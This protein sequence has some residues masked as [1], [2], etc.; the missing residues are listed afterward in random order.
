MFRRLRHK[1]TVLYAGL[2][3]AALLII[4]GT[5][6][7]V[8]A[9]S[10]E[11]LAREQ[12]TQ[13]AALFDH[14]LRLHTQRL[15]GGANAAATTTL[16]QAMDAR[17]DNAI[18]TALRQL[19]TNATADLAFVV[20]REGLV[21]DENGAA[22]SS[23]PPGLQHALAT[24]TAPEGV[25][26]SG[27]RRIQV[28]TARIPGD[29]GW[30]VVGVQLDNS[31]VLLEQMA[32]L[33]L[34]AETVT[35]GRSGWAFGENTDVLAPAVERQM[36][37]DANR[38]ES[39]N[40]DG[41]QTLVLARPMTSVDGARTA[42]VLRHQLSGA[43]SP[44]GTLFGILFLVSCAGLALLLAG[45]W[46]LAR[47]ITRPISTLEVAA[48][49]L[50]DGVFESVEVNSKDEVAQLAE[51]FNAM[52]AA[53]RERERRITQLAYHDA[54]TRMPNRLA[55]ERRLASAPQPERV[56]LAAIGVDRF[57]DVRGAIGYTLAGALMR[58]L[59]QRLSQLVPNAP[60]AR[61]S[62]DVLGVAILADNDADS[63][64]R[65]DS[66]L[67]A[68]EQ[69]ISLEGHDLDVHVS[70]GVAQPRSKTESPGA[71]IER[72][73]VALDQA[74]AA[75]QKVGLFDEAAY[76]DPARNLS[77]MSE[78]RRAIESDA[79]TLAHQP[80]YDF[81]NGAIKGAEA[82]VRW[83][84]PTRGTIA[85]DLFI[86]MAEETGH[87]RALTEWV[88]KRAVADQRKFSDAGWPLTISVNISGRLLGDDD[89]A[90]AAVEIVRTAPHQLCFEITETA[91][92]DNPEAALQN[93]DLFA[94]K[95]VRI[96][97]D[98]YGSG[99]SSLAYLKQLPA[100]ELKIDKLFVESITNSQRDALLVRST[101]DLAHGL[102]LEVVA[103]GIETPAAFAQ[104]ASMKCDL[105]QG[106]LVARP[107]TVEELIA[108]LGDGR[109]MRF[110]QQAAATGAPPHGQ[111]SA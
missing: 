36:Q 3:C 60:V 6:Y 108:I 99:L 12:M 86:P 32:M 91:V 15:Q 54:E 103:E 95:G 14:T 90:R 105:A 89:F 22:Q 78:M 52:T 80:K 98:D 84:H 53:L 85:P 38:A 17:D 25:M 62:S 26:T 43:L 79:L 111:R 94:S 18:R 100:H 9:A 29:A 19:R 27:D 51:S 33:P 88:L 65:A 109:R 87:I 59:G 1:L 11:R 72:A 37:D 20:T 28:A 44:Y 10:T 71:M 50:K 63:R 42:L 34:R 55:L 66:L 41:E 23:V 39:L 102:G 40:L 107:S 2:F 31:V 35:R 92:I 64:K 57:A 45:T 58:T 46:F 97:I 104:L 16:Q 75:R 93:I 24:A 73:S 83:R 82:L 76:G 49:K 69:P 8:I 106:Y 56:Y 67:Q 70:I 7:G 13:A 81:R 5:A 96:S 101:I 77:L 4:G 30:I 61:L 110:Y 47:G 74:R 21:I 68:L 48:R